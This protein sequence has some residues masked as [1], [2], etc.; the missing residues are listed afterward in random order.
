MIACEEEWVNAWS[1]NAGAWPLPTSCL[2]SSSSGQPGTEKA[3]VC[4]DLLA[5]PRDIGGSSVWI[6]DGGIELDQPVVHDASTLC[7]RDR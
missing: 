1:R 3:I 5:G 2:E 4:G 6:E 7:L